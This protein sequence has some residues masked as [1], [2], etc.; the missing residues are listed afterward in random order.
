MRPSPQPARPA[1]EPALPETEPIA[2]DSDEQALP[3]E[4]RPHQPALNA[5]QR[6]YLVAFLAWD[7]EAEERLDPAQQGV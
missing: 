7:A 1:Q 5:R 6:D 4:L 3:E 2:I